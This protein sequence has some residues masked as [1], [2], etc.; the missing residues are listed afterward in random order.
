MSGRK[1]RNYSD[2]IGENSLEMVYIEYIRELA[3]RTVSKQM[4]KKTKIRNTTKVFDEMFIWVFSVIFFFTF[5]R[6]KR[7]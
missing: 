5:H 1:R 4:Q 6:P 2:V 3:G 7:H